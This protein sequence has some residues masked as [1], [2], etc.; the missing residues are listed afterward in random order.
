MKKKATKNITPKTIDPR[1]K[2]FPK[3]E[4]LDMDMPM[5]APKDGEIISDNIIDTS[6]WSEHHELIV[7]FKDQ[8]GTDE[9]YRFYYSNGLTECQ[10]ESPWENDGDE[11]EGTLVK[12]T[13][14][15]VEVWE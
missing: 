12:K 15:V 10:D 2:M 14:K 5:F 7:Q 3:K 6:R 4:L 13:T 11:I 9:A 8:W 1:V